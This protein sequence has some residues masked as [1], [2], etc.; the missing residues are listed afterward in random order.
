MKNKANKEVSKALREMAEDVLTELKN[1][2]NGMF[3]L[4]KGL[5][6]YSK[7]VGGR[8]MRGSDGKLCFSE[9]HRCKV[10]KDYM[11]SPWTFRSITRVDCCYLGV[12][13]QV[14]T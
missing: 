14:M 8:C 11:K 1:C 5:K 6:D 10:C 7:K 4:M 9:K 12:E 13:I 2:P 3:W